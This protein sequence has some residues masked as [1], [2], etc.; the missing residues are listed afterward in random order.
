MKLIEVGALY[1]K[2][3]PEIYDNYCAL[4]ALTEQLKQAVVNARETT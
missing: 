4:V 1:E 3:H 2:D